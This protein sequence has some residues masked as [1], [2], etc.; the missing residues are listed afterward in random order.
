M[1][2]FRKLQRKLVEPMTDASSIRLTKEPNTWTNCKEA[3]QVPKHS[4]HKVNPEILR[5]ERVQFSTSRANEQ[6]DLR[7]WKQR[8]ASKMQL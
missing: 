1:T 8:V 2:E 3:I 4:T 7:G 5:M 6:F